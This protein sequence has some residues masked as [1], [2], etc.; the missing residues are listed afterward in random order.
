MG[1]YD[2]Y[3]DKAVEHPEWEKIRSELCEDD[4]N[5]TITQLY[6]DNG[7]SIYYGEGFE[8]QLE[9]KKSELFGNICWWISHGPYYCKTAP[10]HIKVY[11]KRLDLI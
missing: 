8:T 10:N 6:N 3:I 5:Y 11:L 7:S 4:S 2:D 1:L 9:L